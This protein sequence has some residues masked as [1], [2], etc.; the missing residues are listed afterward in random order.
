MEINIF[1]FMRD[2]MVIAYMFVLRIGVP[3]LI[4]LFWGMA[5]KKW[6]DKPSPETATPAPAKKQEA[7]EP[8]KR[9]DVPV[10]L[11]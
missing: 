8:G 5:L 9:E 1:N 2:A 3:L 11:H 7:N 4:V 6:L 10:V